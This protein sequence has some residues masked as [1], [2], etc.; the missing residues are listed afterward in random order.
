VTP[1]GRVLLIVVSRV[2]AADGPAPRPTERRVVVWAGLV[3]GSGGPQE[4][5]QLASAGHND[6]VVRLAARFHGAVDGV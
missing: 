5:G 3:G 2:P 4:A 6:D 1:V